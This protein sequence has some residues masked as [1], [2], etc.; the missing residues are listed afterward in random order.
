MVDL[1]ANQQDLRE[2]DLTGFCHERVSMPDRYAKTP[3]RV[4]RIRRCVLRAFVII[5]IGS[6]PA[7]AEEPDL[8]SRIARSMVTGANFNR[9]LP[10]PGQ[11][12]FCWPGNLV[13]FD[14]EELVLVHSAGYYHVS[15]AEPRRIEAST[16][17]RWLKSGWPLDFQ[18]PNGGRSMLVRSND[19]GAKWSRPE[20]ILDLPWD[21]SPCGLLLCHDGTLLCFINVQASWYGFPA[22]PPPFDRDL[23]GLNTSQCVIRSTDRGRTWSEPVWIRS[24]GNF[25]QR[26]HAQPIQLASGRILWP[27][28]CRSQQEDR[29]FGAIQA[30]DDSGRTWRVLSTVRREGNPADAAAIDAGNIDEPAL[31]ELRDGRLLLISRPD[32]GR[33]LSDDGGRKWTYQGQL[34]STGKLKAPRI[35]VLEDGTVICVCTYRNLQVFIGRSNGSSWSGPHDLD[36]ESYGYPGGILLSDQSMLISYCSSGKAPNDLYVIRFRVNKD[37][38]GIVRV[39]VNER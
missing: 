32:G 29:L 33:F 25:Y 39:P 28:Y 20:T 1:S 18:A 11:G 34:V 38:T 23:D 14:D 12:R 24:P 22:A 37:R 8:T 19:G 7:V 15:F 16:R 10:F 13:Q 27:T 3:P 4:G 2:S 30:S 35:F 26:S 5:L 31:A 21:D 9:P 17:E 6:G 36:T